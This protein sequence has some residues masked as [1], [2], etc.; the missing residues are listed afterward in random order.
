MDNSGAENDPTLEDFGRG[1]A[2]KVIKKLAELYAKTFT[3]EPWMPHRP[4]AVGIGQVLVDTGVITH[5]ESKA[6]KWYTPGFAF[7]I[8]QRC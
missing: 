3:A 8:L 1:R 4:L 5:A 6:L 2:N 7:G